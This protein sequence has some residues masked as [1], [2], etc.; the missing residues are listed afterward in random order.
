MTINL[1]IV[2]IKLVEKIYISSDEA[3]ASDEYKKEI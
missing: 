3:R 1:E 2:Y